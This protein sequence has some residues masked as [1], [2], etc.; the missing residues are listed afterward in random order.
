VHGAVAG[1][2]DEPTH[3]WRGAMPAA[4]SVPLAAF[5]LVAC[6]WLFREMARREWPGAESVMRWVCD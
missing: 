3:S 2:G 4:V 6:Y 1:A 5:G